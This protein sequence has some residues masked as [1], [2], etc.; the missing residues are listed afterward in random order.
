MKIIRTLEKFQSYKLRFMPNISNPSES[1]LNIKM[2]I[3]G[4]CIV[5]KDFI[6]ILDDGQIEVMIIGRSILESIKQCINGYMGT[7]DGR[8]IINCDYNPE[9]NSISQNLDCFNRKGNL[10]KYYA[11]A[12]KSKITIDKIEAKKGN[13]LE[14]TDIVKYEPRNPFDIKSGLCLEFD[15]SEVCYGI[16]GYLSFI[17]LRWV[18]DTP[19]YKDGDSKDDIT[20]L[21]NNV[22]KLDE[23]KEFYKNEMS[24]EYGAIFDEEAYKSYWDMKN[25]ERIQK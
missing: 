24:E 6:Y 21:Y 16:N 2:L 12:D 7:S 10:I 22:P 18:N 15:T 20:N 11:N 19:I 25:L 5:K 1:I 23:A 4:G 8:Y 3:K 17:N 13:L 9:S 14:F